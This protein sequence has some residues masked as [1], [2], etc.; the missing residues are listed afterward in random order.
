MRAHLKSLPLLILIAGQLSLS[1]S[2]PL[3][4][5][6]LR[7]W[8]TYKNANYITSLSEGPEYVYFG[9]SGGVLLFHKFGRYWEQPFTVSN[10]MS[11]D[12]VSAVVFD[13]QNYILWAAHQKG[14]SYLRPGALSWSNIDKA[15]LQMDDK[16][17]IIRLGTTNQAIW[18]ATDDQRYIQINKYNLDDI[19][20]ADV[21]PYGVEWAPSR[22]DS[23]PNLI[24]YSFTNN[25]QLDARGNL[26]D[27]YLR[28]FPLIIFHTNKQSDV[29]G[30]SWGLGAFEGNTLSKFLR[31]SPMGPLQNNITALAINADY[32]WA[33]N[34]S[35]I[36]GDAYSRF[37]VSE[38]KKREQSWAYYESGVIT[39]LASS[40]VNDL[41]YN[42]NYL[43]VGTE[44]G[45][46]LLDLKR[47]RWRRFSM[48]QGLT[49]EVI[50]CLEAT[51]SLIWIGTPRGLSILTLPKMTIRRFRLDP[52]FLTTGINRIKQDGE[53]VWFSTKNGIYILNRKNE[54]LS[55]IDQFGQEVSLKTPVAG[56]YGPIA[57]NNLWVVINRNRGLL[58]LD[59]K[60]EQWLE[61]PNLAN[62]AELTVNDLALKDNIL[63]VAT[64][65]GAVMLRLPDYYYETYSRADGL[66]DDV[67]NR[68]FV[69][70]DLVWFGTAQG[71]TSFKWSKYVHQY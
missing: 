46:S 52:N 49:D 36:T 71:L 19:W 32:I 34:T 35:L 41:V 62:L 2:R 1:Q 6:E 9:S 40:V 70:E 67:I 51:D 38:F 64:N 10:G 20:V 69:D 24:N 11:D 45:L 39:E 12:F 30:G 47:N 22:Y 57:V 3:R 28:P 4:T 16:I 7:D 43:C 17:Q 54:K 31:F 61:L 15:Q 58:A 60:N 66:P 5:Y 44:Q 13:N 65:K 42:H 68:V 29:F 23:V 50:T 53:K 63:W 26:L 25:F 56:D 37:G 33:G 59:K 14:I 48:A 8:N 21:R 27:N 55:H 18:L